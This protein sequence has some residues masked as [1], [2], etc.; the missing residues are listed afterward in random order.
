MPIILG[1]KQRCPDCGAIAFGS[2]QIRQAW[3][4]QDYLELACEKCWTTYRCDL[5]RLEK[6]IL[7]LDQHAISLMMRS[8][9][10]GKND[11][12]SNLF[13]RLKPLVQ[14][15]RII[16]P[17]SWEHQQESELSVSRYSSLMK[18]CRTLAMGN[19]LRGSREIQNTQ[20]YEA[21]KAFM[22]GE[23]ATWHFESRDAFKDDPN[24]WH[25][26][27]AIDVD[28]DRQPKQVADRRQSKMDVHKVMES[29][30]SD[31]EYLQG[32]FEEYVQRETE[33]F[34]HGL[35]GVYDKDRGELLEM[36]CGLRPPDPLALLSSPGTQV[37]QRVL[38]TIQQE[39]CADD[40]NSKVREFFFSPQFASVPV[41]NINAILG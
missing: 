37:V 41:V 24:A 39:S 8:Q 12:W 6:K 19:R 40:H 15:Q 17:T 35:I 23:G 14:W 30:Y 26:Y 27:F 21:L 33:G 20:I 5:P 28:F 34:A 10:T 13:D 29:L 9:E 32:S 18:T 36:M 22:R 4:G 16:C 7:Y 11:L 3:G 38:M 1:K 25:N 31:P 2:L